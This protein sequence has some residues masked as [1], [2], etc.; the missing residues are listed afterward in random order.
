M[1]SAASY[2]CHI[3][4]VDD[5]STYVHVMDLVRYIH[6]AVLLILSCLWCARARRRRMYLAYGLITGSKST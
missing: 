4:S 1:V 2:D 5:L 3:E 6:Y